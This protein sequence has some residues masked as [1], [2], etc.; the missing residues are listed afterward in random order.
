M[1]ENLS[2]TDNLGLERSDINLLHILLVAPLL[3]YVGY[4]QGRVDK[5]IHTLLLVLGVVVGLYHAK[6][7]NDVKRVL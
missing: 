5:R 1:L 2:R 6:R 3:I 4:N 7:Y